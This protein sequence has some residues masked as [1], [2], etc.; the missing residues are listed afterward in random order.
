MTI[1]IRT[2]INKAR[3]TSLKPPT[4]FG[5]KGHSKGLLYKLHIKM[6]VSMLSFLQRNNHKLFLTMLDLVGVFA[7]TCL[8]LIE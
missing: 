8:P 2:K 6:V 3:Q 1:K 7:H 5:H 4:Q